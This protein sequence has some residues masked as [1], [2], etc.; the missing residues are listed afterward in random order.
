[1]RA[2]PLTL[3]L[4]V[5][6]CSSPGPRPEAPGGGVE[7]ALGGIGTVLYRDPAELLVAIRAAQVLDESYGAVAERLGY[8]REGPV[9]IWIDDLDEPAATYP[10]R[11]VL[12]PDR[13]G[14]APTVERADLILAHE[15]VHWHAHGTPLAKH[16]P[17]GLVEGLADQVA[18]A[19]NPEY[20]AAH[21]RRCDELVKHT[22]ATGS[23]S[24]RLDQ[25]ASDPEAWSR[26]DRRTRDE[27]AAA[28]FLLVEQIGIEGLREAAEA[29][30][31]SISKLLRSAGVSRD[32]AG[33]PLLNTP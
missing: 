25:L 31:V 20:R 8:R 27:A 29:G 33:L 10:D 7:R 21:A 13:T 24:R 2:L 28:A 15:F 6:A 18:T 11:I 5:A 22:L 30:R 14:A 17:H 4:L 23:F 1:M 26:L 16:L 12:R 3:L 9:E 19:L 32:G